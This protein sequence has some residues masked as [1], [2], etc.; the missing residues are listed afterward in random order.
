MFKSPKRPS[1]S[2]YQRVEN[3][4][5]GLND[6][7]LQV[8]PESRNE[9]TNLTSALGKIS[10]NLDQMH[11]MPE[12]SPDKIKIRHQNRK[13]LEAAQ[14][15]LAKLV[16]DYNSK[17]K[18]LGDETKM[19]Q[20][21]R[22]DRERFIL[23]QAEIK[24]LYV[25]N[26][27]ESVRSQSIQ[28]AKEPRRARK[29]RNKDQKQAPMLQEEQQFMQEYTTTLQEQDQLLDQI[30]QGMDELKNI[31]IDMGKELKR[32]KLDLDKLDEKV[33]TNR[34]KLKKANKSLKEILT[35]DS[36]CCVWM[37]RFILAVIFL[38][39]VSTVISRN[40]F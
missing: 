14:K 31:A 38:A 15:D 9:E 8:D 1:T 33:D 18:K 13:D 4:K 2:D 19:P 29:N 22:N 10:K 11:Q 36:S 35:S 6:I 24:Q 25:Q 17:H 34:D 20:E 12:E 40:G 32:Q 3:I 16:L 21:E 5:T 39:L 7:L 27:H 26:L 23:A 28:E 37:T 30:S